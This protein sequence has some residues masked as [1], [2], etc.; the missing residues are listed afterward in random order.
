M[1]RVIFYLRSETPYVEVSG[2]ARLHRAA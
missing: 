2:A 1:S